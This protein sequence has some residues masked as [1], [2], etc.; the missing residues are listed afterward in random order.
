MSHRD[1]CRF[2][3]LVPQPTVCLM[4]YSRQ[5][6][7]PCSRLPITEFPIDFTLLGVPDRHP[8]VAFLPYQTQSTR[9]A[10][11]HLG[12]VWELAERDRYLLHADPRNVRSQVD[13][14]TNSGVKLPL[15]T[16]TP[17]YRWL[18]YSRSVAFG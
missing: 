13:M 15:S 18:Y 17:M 10:H 2:T 4:H 3:R 1:V 12:G 9:R 7:V 8:R 14:Q 5:Q 11:E 6:Q 16:G